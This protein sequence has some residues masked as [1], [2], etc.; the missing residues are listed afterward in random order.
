[1]WR[2]GGVWRRFARCARSQTRLTADP[3]MPDNITTAASASASSSA[4]ASSFRR[5]RRPTASPGEALGLRARSIRVAAHCS[6]LAIC[7]CS[8]H[9][10]TF[11]PRPTTPRTTQPTN[12]PAVVLSFVVAGISAI[13]STLCYSEFAVRF[14]LSG[15]CA[16]PFFL[17]TPPPPGA[18][19]QPRVALP[20]PPNS[21]A[22]TI[23]TT[24][25]TISPPPPP[26]PPLH[27]NNITTH[28]HTTTAPSTT[29]SSRAASSSRSA[30]SARSSSSMSSPTPR[31][32]ARSRRTWGSSSA[33]GRG[34]SRSPSRVSRRVVCAC[35]LLWVEG[36]ACAAISPRPALCACTPRL[37][38]PP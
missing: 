11:V 16:R 5:G 6:P 8:A 35:C 17:S 18:L 28:I 20:A 29:C 1:M 23:T 13:L 12:S 19:L 2:R 36:W 34:S 25:T 21:T 7:A 10:P 9:R 24:I 30:A 33:R 22:T 4:P 32:R 3:H 27:T 31:S 37:C 38:K 14:P 15:G 26:P